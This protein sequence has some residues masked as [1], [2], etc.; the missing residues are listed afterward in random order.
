MEKAVEAWTLWVAWSS[1]RFVLAE[2]R[3]SGACDEWVLQHWAYGEEMFFLAACFVGQA[4]GE[5]VV[6]D[7]LA[8]KEPSSSVQW[9]E[10]ET[11]SPR[12]DD[13]RR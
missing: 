12:R 7:F 9:V 6:A 13:A 11:L 2:C 5:K 1:R 3:K 10:F 4:V 8:T